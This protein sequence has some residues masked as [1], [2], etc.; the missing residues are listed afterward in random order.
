MNGKIIPQTVT[1]EVGDGRNTLFWKDKWLH[2]QSIAQ[3][4]PTLVELVPRRVASRRT[5]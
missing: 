2:G 4:A 5:D 1:T 3:I